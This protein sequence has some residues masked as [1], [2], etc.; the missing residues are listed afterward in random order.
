MTFL[1]V[2]WR[3]YRAPREKQRSTTCRRNDLAI[4]RWR[5]AGR[6][7]AASEVIETTTM[8]PFLEGVTTPEAYERWPMMPF[9]ISAA[10]GLSHVIEA[11]RGE[12]RQVD[13]DQ[14]VQ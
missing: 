7:Y 4:C 14:A 1:E 10:C 9:P 13:A 12:L 6:S 2:D 5:L 8:P 3:Y 11:Q